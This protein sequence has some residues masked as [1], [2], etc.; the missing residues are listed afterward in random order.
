LIG[1]NVVIDNKNFAFKGFN[2][3]IMSCLPWDY[4]ANFNMGMGYGGLATANGLTGCIVTIPSPAS[5]FKKPGFLKKPG[6]WRASCPTS[7]KKPGFHTVKCLCPIGARFG[8]GPSKGK[9]L[10][11]IAHVLEMDPV[12]VKFCAQLRTILGRF[13]IQSGE[14]P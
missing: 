14:W 7:T 10:C 3:K 2:H 6:F 12:N 13:V 1:V 4:L 5:R 8:D 11:A 9:F